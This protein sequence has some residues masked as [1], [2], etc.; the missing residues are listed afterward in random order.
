MIFFLFLF[1][2]FIFGFCLQIFL[3]THDCIKNPK[4]SN[5]LCTFFLIYSLHNNEN[6]ILKILLL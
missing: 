2:F 3:L 6:I 1:L 5:V 4:T